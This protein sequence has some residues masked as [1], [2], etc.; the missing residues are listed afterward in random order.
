MQSVTIP[1][2][3]TELGEQVFEACDNLHTIIYEGY[4]TVISN[5]AIHPLIGCVHLD[6][7]IAPAALWH[8]TNADK[9][10]ENRYGV[11]HKARYIEVTDGDLTNQSVKYIAQNATALEVL[12]L[13]NTTNTTLPYGAFSH[14]YLLTQLYLPAYIETLPESM[15]EGGSRLS[16]ITIPATVTEIGNYA[17]AGCVNIWRMTVEATTPPKV[18]ENTFDGVNRSISVLVPAGSEQAYREAEYWR[19]FFIDNTN[20]PLPISNCQKIFH[21]DQILIL[22]NGKAYTTMGQLINTE[23]E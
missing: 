6:T 16:E 23:K 3:V 20:S 7:V 1:A 17:F 5:Q 15:I 22:R 18:Y 19:E 14:S 21:E 4:P 13:T 2:S 11:P 10:L 12:D 8:C 9:A